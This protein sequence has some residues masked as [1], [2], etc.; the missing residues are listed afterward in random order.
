MSPLIGSTGHA[1]LGPGDLVPATLTLSKSGFIVNCASAPHSMKPVADIPSS[2]TEIIEHRNL[3][4]TNR[5]SSV[6]R[7]MK[8]AIRGLL[9]GIVAT[10]VLT[11]NGTLKT[12]SGDTSVAYWLIMCC[13][14]ALMKILLYRV[15][16]K[17]LELVIF[18]IYVQS[19]SCFDFAVEKANLDS[20]LGAF[21]AEKL[22]VLAASETAP[23]QNGGN[24]RSESG[25][26]LRHTLLI[27][28]VILLFV[29]TG[30]NKHGKKSADALSGDDR[31]AGKDVEYIIRIFGVETS[32]AATNGHAGEAKMEDKDFHGAIEEFTKA[33]KLNPK[34]E[35]FYIWRAMAKM[36]LEDY[37]ATLVDLNKLIEID[38]KNNTYYRLRAIVE[39]R[40]KDNKHAGNDLQKAA[41]L[42]P[43]DTEARGLMSDFTNGVE[44]TDWKKL[45]NKGLFFSTKNAVFPSKGIMIMQPTLTFFTSNTVTK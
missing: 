17:H 35:N 1:L 43:D 18:S 30:C 25:N 39:I 13:A 6:E 34:W 31:V 24:I 37:A 12:P 10:I 36:D 15:R 32:E 42:A 11:L 41:E 21:S 38:P 28:L 23:H 7:T 22:T 29:F 45:L 19:G 27:L 9:M 20:A 33:I 40:L 16:T 4:I 3:V 5:T 8:G 44:I 14:G 2:E 26:G